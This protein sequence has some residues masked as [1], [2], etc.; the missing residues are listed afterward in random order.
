MK[1]VTDHV[2]TTDPIVSYGSCCSVLPD[3]QIQFLCQLQVVPDMLNNTSLTG[4]AGHEQGK[5]QF[6]EFHLT[7]VRDIS[8]NTAIALNS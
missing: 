8:T 7:E 3:F 1:H 4:S 6:S 5:S 2:N